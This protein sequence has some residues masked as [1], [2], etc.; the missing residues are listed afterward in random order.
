M[1]REEGEGRRSTG[2]EGGEKEERRKEG[3]EGGTE[4]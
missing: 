2:K 3:K 4:D 1:R